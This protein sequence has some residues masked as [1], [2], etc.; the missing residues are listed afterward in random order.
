MF[1]NVLLSSLHLISIITKSPSQP[2]SLA[3]VFRE[4]EHVFDDVWPL[5]R[6][7]VVR[8]GAQNI[9]W[10]AGKREGSLWHSAQLLLGTLATPTFQH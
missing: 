10:K 2:L 1:V 4:Y 8:P 9:G 3:C 5:L 7:R 6:V